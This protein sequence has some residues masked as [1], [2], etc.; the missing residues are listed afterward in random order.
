VDHLLDLVVSLAP[1]QWVLSGLSAFTVGLSKTG[2]PG[3][4]LVF[5]PMMA[6]AFGAKVSTGVLLPILNM[7]DLFAVSY[8]RRSADVPKLFS[9]LPWALAGL[10]AGVTVGQSMPDREFKLMLG[11]V[12]LVLLALMIWQEFRKSDTVPSGWWFP[13]VAGFAAGFTTMVG[14]AAGPVM[15]LYLLAMRLPKNAYIGTSAWFFLI[16][17][18]IKV[19]LQIVF[20]HNISWASFAIDVCVL[21]AIALGAWLGV[22]ITGKIPEKAFKILVMAM[23][24]VSAVFL[25]L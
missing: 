11:I 13:A 16:L 19:P 14:N 1:F 15:S 18:L 20:W 22:K 24:G 12:V 7:G 4:G 9:L 10:A 6:I 25:L 8:Y 2:L 17:N 23:T 5:V 3:L 21:P